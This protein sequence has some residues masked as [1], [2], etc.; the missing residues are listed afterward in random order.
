MVAPVGEISADTLTNHKEF[1]GLSIPVRAGDLVMLRGVNCSPGFVTSGAIT[2][3]GHIIMTEVTDKTLN[4]PVGQT[5]TGTTSHGLVVGHYAEVLTGGFQPGGTLALIGT[6]GHLLPTLYRQADQPWNGKKVSAVGT[7]ITAMNP[8]PG[9]GATNTGF[10]NQTF[11]NCQMNG[12][13][14]GVGSSTL[15]YPP[16]GNPTRSSLSAT[17]AELTAIGLSPAGSYENSIIAFAPD[18]VIIDHATNDD[19]FS[20]GAMYAGDGSLNKDRGT[21]IGAYNY[22]IDKILTSLPNCRIVLLTPSSIY[23]PGFVNPTAT[24]PDANKNAGLVQRCVDIKAVGAYYGFPVLDMQ[25]KLALHSRA[26]MPAQS[27]TNNFGSIDGLHPTQA[28]HNVM[29]RILT[30]FLN[31]I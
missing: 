26:M 12:T 15:V 23:A 8:A 30:Q 5:L 16:G 27:D 22:V 2:V 7:S 9:G 20:S 14:F 4:S 18:L 19:G 31:G 21:F 28:T 1:S 29:A 24:T 25:T 6:D 11:R 3:N 17:A 13:N 10:V